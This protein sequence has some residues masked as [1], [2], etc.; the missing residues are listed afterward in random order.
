[1]MAMSKLDQSKVKWIMEHQQRD[2]YAESSVYYS[3]LYFFV[4]AVNSIPTPRDPVDSRGEPARSFCTIPTPS[5]A[6]SDTLH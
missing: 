5:G 1:M 3:I 4:R 6:V 2:C